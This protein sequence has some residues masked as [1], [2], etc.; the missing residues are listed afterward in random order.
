[1]HFISNALCHGLTAKIAAKIR[2]TRDAIDDALDRRFDSV[3]FIK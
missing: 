1:V 2:R 3:R